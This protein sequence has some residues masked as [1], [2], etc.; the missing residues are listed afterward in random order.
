MY[1]FHHQKQNQKLTTAICTF[2][3]EL[4]SQYYKLF[5]YSNVYI[6]EF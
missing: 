6:F 1:L 2:K 4:Y 5:I 3:Y